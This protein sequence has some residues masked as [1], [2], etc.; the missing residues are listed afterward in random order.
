MVANATLPAASFCSCSAN[1]MMSQP[2]DSTTERWTASCSRFS[3][4][5]LDS[6]LLEITSWASA[7]ITACWRVD[8]VEVTARQVVALP[9][10][11][12]RLRAVQLLPAGREV[13]ARKRFVYGVFQADVDAAEGIGD[14]REAEQPDLGVVVDGDPGQVGDGLDQRL[15]TGF[16]GLRLGL[17][18]IHA[19]LFDELLLLLH[20]DRAVDAVD[21]HLANARRLDVG[22]ARNRDRGGGLP[23]VGDAHQDDGVGVGRH[24]VAGPQCGQLL[25][26]QGI[27]VRVGAA[28]HA[29]QQDVDRA[30]LAAVAQR[31]R[32]DVV[33]AGFERPDLA[34]RDTRA[35]HDRQVPPTRR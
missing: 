31:D 29:D 16:G 14:Q 11:A 9:D 12:Q 25:R 34:P 3:V 35:D 20:V 6:V 13:G 1:S 2:S 8:P 19:L 33:D 26:R 7:A 18:R 10:E 22:V 30:V 21:L 4:A 15:A 32:G 17:S 5:G 27:A 24:V 28:V 23:V